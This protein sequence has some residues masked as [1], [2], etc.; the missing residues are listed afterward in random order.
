MISVTSAGTYTVTVTD[1]SNGCTGT[2]ELMIT[3]DPGLFVVETTP[4]MTLCEGQTAYL[5]AYVP[6]GTG[7]YTFDWDN[8]LGTGA[9]Q[10]V[11]VSGNT[12]MVYTVTVTNELGCEVVAQTT[13]TPTPDNPPSITCPGDIS[14]N[15]DAGICGADIALPP[16][17]AT[18]DCAPPMLTGSNG[19]PLVYVGTYNGHYYYV[20]GVN[21]TPSEIPGT[22]TQPEAFAAVQATAAEFGGYIATV[23]DAGENNFV[24]ETGYHFGNL[25]IGLTDEQVEGSPGWVGTCCGGDGTGY[26]NWNGGEPNNAGDEDYV[27]VQLANGGWNDVDLELSIREAIVEF[28]MVPQMV[29]VTCDATSGVFPVGTT[30]VTCTATDWAGQSVSCSYDVTVTDNEAPTAICQDITISLDASGNANIVA[31]DVD[32][33]STDNC[34]IE[35]ITVT[36]TDFTC[37]NIGDNTV[38]LTVTDIYGNSSSCDATVTVTGQGDVTPVITGDTESLRMVDWRPDPGH[39]RFRHGRIHGDRDEY[40]WLCGNCKHH[41]YRWSG[42]CVGCD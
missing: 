13:I 4:D 23:D 42:S 11:L 14:G 5:G 7:V 30:T 26:T 18:D 15:N 40:E 25:L 2:A 8:G 10:T 36:P 22:T 34:T 41:S 38:T 12:P 24:V 37:A 6:D 29:E 28:P 1:A 16:T 33:G 39:Y 21:M 31:N 9:A 19:V 35:S 27:E 3:E 32:G 20:T 17:T